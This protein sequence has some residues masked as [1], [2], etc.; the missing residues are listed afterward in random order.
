M[1]NYHINYHYI[2]K[3]TSH[4]AELCASWAILW[5]GP[6]GSVSG[7]HTGSA[8][9]LLSADPA[10]YPVSFTVVTH[11]GSG[12][13]W[14]PVSFCGRLPI[15]EGQGLAPNTKTCDFKSSIIIPFW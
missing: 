4:T 14:G 2:V 13:V 6:P 11:A 7:S 12:T 10:L 3:T 15:L 8:K 1:V 9:P 5:E